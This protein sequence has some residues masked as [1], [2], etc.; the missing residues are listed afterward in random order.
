MAGRRAMEVEKETLL[1]RVEASKRVI[2]AGRRESL[3]LEKQVKELERRLQHSQGETRAAEER[4]QAFLG[5]VASLLQVKSETVVVPTEQDVLHIVENLCNK[6]RCKDIQQ[7]V[8]ELMLEKASILH[9][10]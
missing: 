7:S 8:H 3:C 5:K 6:V 1:E 4:L 9:L 10:V 2:E